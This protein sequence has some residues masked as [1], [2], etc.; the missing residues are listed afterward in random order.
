MTR[1]EFNRLKAR[2]ERLRR[3]SA[4]ESNPAAKRK[5]QAECRALW[6]RLQPYVENARPFDGEEGDWKAD[7]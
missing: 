5:M 3:D 1:E 2:L 7:E 4:E 6:R